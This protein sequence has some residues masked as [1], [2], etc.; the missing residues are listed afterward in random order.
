MVTAQ[1]VQENTVV[2]ATDQGHLAP[3]AQ[4][5]FPQRYERAYPSNVR[6]FVDLVRDNTVEDP[7]IVRRHIDLERVTAAAELSH[8]LGRPI[9]LDEVDGLR[10]HLSHHLSKPAPGAPPA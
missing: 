6:Q 10:S 2:V 8:V 9:R 7:S 3:R 1:N 4:W 5:S